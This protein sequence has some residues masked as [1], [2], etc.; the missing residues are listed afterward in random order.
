MSNSEELA[1]HLAGRLREL[2]KAAGL[3]GI[4]LGAQLGWT[5]SKVSKTETGRTTL[6]SEDDITAWVQACGGAGEEAAVLTAILASLHTEQR[7]WRAKFRHGQAL[8]QEEYARLGRE[9]TL[10]RNFEPAAIPGLLQTAGY[11]RARTMEGV[12]RQGADPAPTAVDRSVTARLQRGQALFED[13][14][15][16][17]FILGE[18][19]LRWRLAPDNDMQIQLNRLISLSELPNVTLAVLPFSA[20]M[21]ETPQHGFVIYDNVAIVET[22]V[23]ED[24]IEGK[25][26][27]MLAAIFASFMELAVTGD[28]ARQLIVAAMRALDSNSPAPHQQGDQANG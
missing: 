2:R 4:E 20:L 26:A 13:G 22:W 5:Q 15:R 8:T 23:S 18:P 6:P 19:A 11:A 25:R 1:K 24:R 14:K 12:I 21:A 16:F 3:S 17:E 7:T 10:V 9:A 27:D 28:D